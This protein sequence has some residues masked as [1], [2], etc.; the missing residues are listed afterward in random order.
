MLKLTLTVAVLGMTAMLVLSNTGA[1][2][3]VLSLS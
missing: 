1:L 3:A 2:A